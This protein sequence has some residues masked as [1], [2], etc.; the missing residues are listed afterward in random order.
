MKG[1]GLDAVIGKIKTAIGKNAVNIK[2]DQANV[3][4][5]VETATHISPSRNRS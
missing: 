3:A 4:K 2:C 5:P 1:L